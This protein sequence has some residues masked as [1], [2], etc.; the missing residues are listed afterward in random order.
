MIPENQRRRTRAAKETIGRGRGP[1]EAQPLRITKEES[2]A[3]RLRRHD[4]AVRR[5]P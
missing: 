1:L 2:R 5:I 4:E 3:L